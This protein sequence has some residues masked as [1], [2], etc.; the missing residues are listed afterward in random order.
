MCPQSA[1]RYFR[2][3]RY[4]LG[5][6]TSYDFLFASCGCFHYEMGSHDERGSRLAVSIAGGF[7]NVGDRAHTL[8]RAAVVNVGIVPVPGSDCSRG[9]SHYE[10]H[11]ELG[12]HFP[13]NTRG[14]FH[15]EC[16]DCAPIRMNHF[17]AVDNIPIPAGQIC[18]SLGDPSSWSTKEGLRRLPHSCTG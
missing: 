6:D 5:T 16:V 3:F 12:S 10:G 17:P 7:H 14:R 13:A 18:G 2:Y 4:F 1:N 11:R 15:K 9:G 8:R